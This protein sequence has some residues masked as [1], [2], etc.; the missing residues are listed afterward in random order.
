[1]NATKE[2]ILRLIHTQGPISVAHYMAIALTDPESG[3]YMRCD[4]LGRDFIT[5]PEV[6]QIF[7]ELIGLFF[8]QAWEDRGRPRRFHLVE[9]G[10]GRGTLMAD[11][12]RTAKIRPGFGDAAQITLIEASPVLRDIQAKT[13]TGAQVA[14]RKDLR[15]VP[16]DGPLFLIANEFFDALPVHQFIRRNGRWRERMVSVDGDDLTFAATPDPVP[17]SIVPVHL[18][19]APEGAIFETS[20]ASQAIAHDIARRIR[21][22]G[23]AALVI[24]YGHATSGVGDTFQAVRANRFFDPLSEPGEADLTCHVDFAALASA[25]RQAEGYVFG[26]APQ[27]SFLESLGIHARAERLRRAAPENAAEINQ[28]V[29]RLINPLQMGMLFK[30]MAICED[31][32]PGVTGF[33]CGS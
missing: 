13:L 18:R 21:E 27:G 25:A 26:P 19:D 16:A 8:V 3:Y 14:W 15:E 31:R 23:G 5:A 28:A 20:P 2:K 30:V 32:S 22:T 9:L 6:S 12:L 10:P 11:L 29:D 24:D 33:S 4:P 1:M 17:D 7:G